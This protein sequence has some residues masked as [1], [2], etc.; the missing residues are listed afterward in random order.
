MT[1]TI[2]YSWHCMNCPE[3]GTTYASADRH[4]KQPGHNVMYEGRPA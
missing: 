2:A 3:T 1:T 4:A